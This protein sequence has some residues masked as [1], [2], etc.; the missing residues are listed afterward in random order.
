MAGCSDRGG[1]ARRQT[2][3]LAQPA[4]RTARRG[5]LALAGHL[6]LNALDWAVNH[7]QEPGH[8]ALVRYADDLVIRCAPGQGTELRERL[9][10][11]LEARG[12]K[13]NE[14]KTRQVHSRD[15]FNFLGFSVRWQ[16]SRRSGRY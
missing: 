4:R 7:P 15:G 6:Y 3:D 5:H 9:G 1:R 11:W 13:L 12:L 2:A 8:P 16:R 10:R 14:E